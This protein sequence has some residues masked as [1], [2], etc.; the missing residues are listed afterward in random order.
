[1]VKLMRSFAASGS[2]SA[3]L[4]CGT[5]ISVPPNPKATAMMATSP[6]T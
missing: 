2:I 3:A 6:V 5:T 1:M 4:K